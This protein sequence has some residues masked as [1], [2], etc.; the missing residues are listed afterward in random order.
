MNFEKNVPLAEFTTL[1]VG[2]SAAFFARVESVADAVAALKFARQK[3][4]PVCALG[5][6]TNILFADAGFRGLVIRSY[7]GQL[8]FPNGGKVRV[9]SG[10]G[11]A[12][13]V[14]ETARRGFAGLEGF[15]GIP[16][17]VGGAVV[18]NANEIGDLVSS[19][20]VL[21][22]AGEKKII[23]PADLKFGYRDS[24]LKSSG[25]FLLEVELT[26]VES[27]TDLPQ[28]VAA[29]AHEKA[30][31]HSIEKT[32]GSWFKNPRG[33]KA[34][35]LIIAAGLHGARVGGAVVSEQHANFFQNAGKAT[36]ADFLALDR[37]VRTAVYEKF[38]INL[39]RE[40]VV[41]AVG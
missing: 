38:G 15:A 14:A 6:G 41:V 37:K 39:E 19:A 1:A 23:L 40:V 33:R 5:G 34:W 2:G 17:T 3:K 18:G 29:A 22:R 16:G 21:D 36:A 11:L 24:A 12:V 25:D 26:L 7:L 35:E 9:G 32:A 28:K 8:D 20:T 10:V 30:A 13:L 31:K 4:M 27:T